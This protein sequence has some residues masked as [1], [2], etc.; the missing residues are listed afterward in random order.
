MGRIRHKSLLFILLVMAAACLNGCASSMKAE[1]SK[2][3]GFVPV[4]EMAKAEDIPFD[5]AWMKEGVEWMNY[6]A[7]YILNVDTQHLIQSTWWQQS[8][9][10]DQMDHDVKQVAEYMQQEFAHAFR[11]DPKKRFQVIGAPA[12]H[13]L[14]LEMALTELV[15]SNVLMETMA[16]A[17]PYGSGVAVKAVEKGSGGQSTV[18]FEA[19]I[20]D[21]ETG[22]I[23]AMFADREQ[24]K[25][26]PVDL[27]GLTWYAEA[28]VIIDEWAD[29]FVAIANKRPGEI[30]KRSSPFS[31]KPW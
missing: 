4:S 2:G 5:K 18:A 19:R 14:T 9:R 11:N 29:Q 3:A 15:P 8:F 23:L 13:A 16:L 12:P 17:A 10:R 27:K 6:S 31:L 22:E 1:P 30:I 20:R 26:N 28:H 24:P 25:L 7:I 21:S